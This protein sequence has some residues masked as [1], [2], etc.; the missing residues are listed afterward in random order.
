VY[1]A[2]ISYGYLGL[3]LGTWALL[4]LLNRPL[5]VMSLWPYLLGGAGLWYCLLQ[6]GIHASIAGVMLAFAIPFTSRRAETLSPSHRLMHALHK[7]VAF[8]ILPLF[9]LA[10]TAL[11]LDSQSLPQLAGANGQGIMLGLVVGKPLGVLLFCALAV[12]ARVCVLPEQVRW[13]HIVGAGLIGGIGFTMSIFISNLAFAGDASL[14]DS[15]KLAVLVAS[16][17]AGALG[18]AWLRTLRSS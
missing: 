1:T 11:V 2:E 16:V 14:I 6:A 8:F 15:S 17:V 9:A 3:A 7:P 4:I 10:N 13:S 18:W 12:L 5:R